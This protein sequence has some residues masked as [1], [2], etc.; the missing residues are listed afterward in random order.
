[1]ITSPIWLPA[2]LMAGGVQAWRT[3]VQRRVGKSL[4]VNAA[5]LV[6]YL[7][8]IPFTLM[9]LAG[10]M[11][12]TG[13]AVPAVGNGF[14]LFCM[15]GGLAQIIATNLLLMAFAHRN[16]VVGTAYS[17]TEAVQSALLSA[18]LLGDRLSLLAWLGIACGV[19]G[20]MILSS[21]GQRLRPAEFIKALGQPAA[22]YGIAS[23]FFFALTAIGIR[24]ATQDV[25]GDDHIHAALLVLC[26]TVA[27]QTFMQGGYLLLRERSQFASVFSSWRVSGQVGFL[28]ALGSACWFTGFATAPVA[29]V[30]IV[31]QIEVL[32]TMMF[33]HFYLR[34]RMHCTE[35]LG[36]LLVVTGVALAL[37]GS[38]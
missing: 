21:G 6:R 16:F 13:K 1:M 2:T 8:G 9:M 20:V 35:A 5:G 11:L 28:S 22:I 25:N 38:L 12:A 3:A 14:L 30:R 17:K 37:A 10:Y 7:Y 36:L 23:G 31:G 4:S 32:F 33:G 27:L 34:E 18:W 24:R 29:L 15:L 26:V 19:A